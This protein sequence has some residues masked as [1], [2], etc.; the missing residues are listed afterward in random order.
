MPNDADAAD[1]KRERSGSAIQM[2]RYDGAA[3]GPIMMTF[4]GLC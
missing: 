3:K 4:I 2:C 1:A